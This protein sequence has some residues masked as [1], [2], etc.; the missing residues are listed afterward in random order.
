[1]NKQ[2]SLIIFI[3]LVFFTKHLYSQDFFTNAELIATFL[4]EERLYDKICV[5]V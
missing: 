4:K 1:M 5:T 3:V 2:V